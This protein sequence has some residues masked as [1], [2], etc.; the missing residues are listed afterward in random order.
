MA[1]HGSVVCLLPYSCITP[2]PSNHR[3]IL[4]I[5]FRGAGG[6][7]LVRFEQGRGF[8]LRVDKHAA[9]EAGHSRAL[10]DIPR[11]RHVQ[12]RRLVQLHP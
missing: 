8:H 9:D 4:L 1:W 5:L 10:R 3:Y 12:R 2:P 11:Q 6:R 7:L